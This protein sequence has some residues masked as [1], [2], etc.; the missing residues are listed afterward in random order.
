[1]FVRLTS[2]NFDP[3]KAEEGDRRNEKIA[4]VVKKMPGMLHSYTARNDQ[5][6]GVVIA[7]WE[8]E[9]AANAA[10]EAVKQAWSNVSDLLTGQPQR[11]AY[12]VVHQLT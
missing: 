2:Y 5:G 10:E 12:P 6:E 11:K 7:F 8:S 1:M 3:S 9:Q 4:A